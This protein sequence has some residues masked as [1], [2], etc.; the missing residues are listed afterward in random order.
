MSTRSILGLVYTLRGLRELGEDIAPILCRFGLDL[1]RLDPGARID[2]ALELRIYI[3]LA[4]HLKDPLAGLKTGTFFGFTGYGPLTMLLLTCN[5]AYEA[6][7]TGVRYQQLTFLFSRLGF[8]PGAT[9]SALTLQ[10]LHVPDKAFRFR[11]DGETSGTYKLIR[12]MQ[13]S[14]GMDVRAEAIFI[15]YPKPPEAKA[16]EEH[17]GC[18]VHFGETPDIRCLMRND[19]LQTRFPTADTAAHAL[20]RQ[21][22]DAQI[23]QQEAVRLEKLPEQ[24]QAYLALFGAG[25]PSALEVATA[26]DIPERSFRRQLSQEGSS[27]R[28]LLE[29]VKQQKAQS[30]L[31]DTR[32]SVEAI[33]QQ[34]GYAESAAF[35]HAFQRWTGS[36]PAAFRNRQS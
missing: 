10:P 11:V 8:E 9:A 14:L 33:A 26:F 5:N 23:Q 35:I 2:R 7:Q 36:T 32:L 27:F 12:D 17:F 20:F 4:Q 13:A 22:C 18:P 28:A 24:V 31:L 6:F 21:Q 1:D 3:E 25:F 29:A 15:P 30:L 16:Y 34:L 19:Y